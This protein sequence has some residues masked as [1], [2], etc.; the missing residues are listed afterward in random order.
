MA[1]NYDNKPLP[2]GMD[3]TPHEKPDGEN[4]MEINKQYGTVSPG[5][6]QDSYEGARGGD[7]SE[8]P[9]KS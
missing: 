4:M 7:G 8:L 6:S 3:L 1:S 2:N 5:G 9:D